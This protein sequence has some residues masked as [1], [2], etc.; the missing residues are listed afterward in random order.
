MGELLAFR[1]VQGFSD[2]HFRRDCPYWPEE[3]YD[4]LTSDRLPH[5]SFCEWCILARCKEIS[6]SLNQ[7]LS[8]IEVK[9]NWCIS[10]TAFYTQHSEQ[11]PFCNSPLGRHVL[12]HGLAG[13]SEIVGQL[14][15]VNRNASNSPSPLEKPAFSSNRPT[16]RSSLSVRG[17]PPAFHHLSS[18]ALA[19]KTPQPCGLDDGAQC[20]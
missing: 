6:E 20:P 13:E 17:R 14:P 12:R 5:G 3:N 1:R 15:N 9:D 11:N 2:W 7:F 8:K 10:R 18:R 16:R 19:R 4:E